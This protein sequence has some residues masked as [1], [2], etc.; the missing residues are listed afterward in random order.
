MLSTD[1]VATSRS[2]TRINVWLKLETLVYLVVP[3]MYEV[4]QRTLVRIPPS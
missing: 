2:D 1:Y 4:A 3:E